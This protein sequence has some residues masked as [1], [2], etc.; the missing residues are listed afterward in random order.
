MAPIHRYASYSNDTVYLLVRNAMC[1]FDAIGCELPGGCLEY[2]HAFPLVGYQGSTFDAAYG[3]D[4][5]FDLERIDDASC[6]PYRGG[7][8]ANEPESAFGVEVPGVTGS[9]PA[10]SAHIDFRQPISDWIGI[11]RKNMPATDNDF[12]DLAIV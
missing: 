5:I 9:M 11:A 2:E 12:T 8:T 4:G 6:I 1:G 10:A 3:T 7:T